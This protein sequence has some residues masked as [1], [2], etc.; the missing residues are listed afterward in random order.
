MIEDFINWLADSKEVYL[1]EKN[2]HTGGNY[3]LDE[4]RI[5]ELV[6]EWKDKSK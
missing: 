6:C 4:W 5:E 1:C 2:T 3:R